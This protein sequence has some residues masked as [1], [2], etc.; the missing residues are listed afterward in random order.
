MELEDL[1]TRRML[2]TNLSAKAFGGFVRGCEI[3]IAACLLLC[4]AAVQA[5]QLSVQEI[6]NKSVVVNEADFKAR[7][8]FDWIEVNRNAKASKKF[9]V[10]IIEG[11]PYYRLI[12]L[13]GEPLSA[14]QDAQE[15]KKLQQVIARRRSETSEQRQERIDNY[16]KERKRDNAMMDEL[17]K[18]FN[19][20][21]LG[22][23]NV[24]G[25]SAYVLKAMPRPGYRPPNME[26]QVLPGMHGELWIDSNSFHWV[27]VTA[28]VI[29]PVSIEGFLAEVQPGTRFELENAPVGDGKIWQPVH[30]SMRSNAKVLYVFQR[31]SQEDDSYSDYRPAGSLKLSAARLP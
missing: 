22:L 8:D 25:F 12:G 17:T 9:Q 30:F 20:T 21:M 24:H 10:T 14:A 6:I 13:N 1:L 29:R 2:K 19:F 16:E 11:T 18:A 23:R 28:Q 4:V 27:K 31:Q 3:S 5:Q 26:T 15:E 7:T